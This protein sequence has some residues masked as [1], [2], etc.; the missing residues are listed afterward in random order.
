LD[1]LF[2]VLAGKAIHNFREDLKAQGE[3][4]EKEVIAYYSKQC[5][6]STQDFKLKVLPAV[7]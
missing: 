6:I 4:P 7:R 2:I 3:I 5:G 1:K